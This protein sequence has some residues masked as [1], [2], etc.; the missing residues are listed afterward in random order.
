MS[1]ESVLVTSDR[2]EESEDDQAA[3]LRAKAEDES[4]KWARYRNQKLERDHV[5]TCGHTPPGMLYIATLSTGEIR[6][7]KCRWCSQ[8][9]DRIEA[10]WLAE[11]EEEERLAKLEREKPRPMEMFA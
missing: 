7:R 5:A 1:D 4:L 8:H 3:R 6:Y 11:K 9:A 2:L 10:Q